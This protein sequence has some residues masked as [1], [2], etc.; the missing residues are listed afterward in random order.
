MSKKKTE[1][2]EHTQ[3][4][5]KFILNLALHFSLDFWIK[6]SLRISG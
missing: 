1:Q 2:A 6:S 4:S 5:K 3:K